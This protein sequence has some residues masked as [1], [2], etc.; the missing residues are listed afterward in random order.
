MR[1]LVGHKVAARH[2]GHLYEGVHDGWEQKGPWEFHVL[3]EARYINHQTN[4]AP[5]QPVKA[6]DNWFPLPG[7]VY[8]PVGPTVIH[9]TH[10]G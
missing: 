2:D 1:E 5:D 10:L 4:A 7:K 6:N 9:L 3:I 8:L